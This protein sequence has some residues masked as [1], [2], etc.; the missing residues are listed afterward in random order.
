MIE[1]VLN[2][3]NLMRAYRQVYANKGSAGVDGMP[4]KELY[5]Y[6]TNNWERIGSE[7]RQGRYLPQSI[8]GSEM[9]KSNGKSRLLGI[10]TMCDRV[11]QEVIRAELERELE[12]HFHPSLYGYRPGKSVPQ[13]LEAC[14]KNCWERWYVVDV[15]IKGFFDNIDHA[16][17]I[18]RL[19]KYTS[20]KHI[21]L[22]CER[23]LKAPILRIKGEMDTDRKKGTPQGGVISPLLANLYLHYCMDEWLK[24]N[25][26]QCLFERYAD[27]AVIH[28]I[29]LSEAREI[30][31]GIRRRFAECGLE[32]HPEKTKIVYCR[33]SNRTEP[34]PV[35][36]YDFLGYT[37]RPRKSMNKQG[38]VF[39]GFLPAVSTQSETMMKAKMR[40]WNTFTITN[41]EVEDIALEINKVVRGWMNYYGHF[42]KTELKYVLAHIDRRLAIWAHRKFKRLRGRKVRA[43]RWVEELAKREPTLFAHWQPTRPRFCERSGL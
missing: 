30:K 13:A 9:L 29:T 41:C 27:D 40:S 20:K 42:Y 22:Y 28:C 15:D 43:I 5:K 4:L 3:R 21:L 33:S 25:F 1:Q 24:R 12:P 14:A 39:T 37:F 16:K 32:L 34:Y 19:H 17:M 7:L 23:W 31:E 26:P 11:A 6:L 10:P 2:R 36:Q 38:V 18:E 8:L 35:V